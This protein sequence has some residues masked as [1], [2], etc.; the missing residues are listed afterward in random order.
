LYSLRHLLQATPAG[1][2]REFIAKLQ[3]LREQE[4]RDVRVRL[5]A[6]TLASILER[7]TADT[8][9]EYQWLSSSFVTSNLENSSQVRS[10]AQRMLDFADRRAETATLLVNTVRDT[11]KPQAVRT[12]SYSVFDDPRLFQFD[13]PDPI[14]D[15]VFAATVEMLRSPDAEM[16]RSGAGLLLNLCTAIRSS[17]RGMYLQSARASIETAIGAEVDDAVKVLLQ[18]YL[19]LISRLPA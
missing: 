1:T 17:N 13:Q 14:S 2:D 3:Q 18:A 5:A 7:G 4:S 8:D 16:R 6:S 12:S 19:E 9:E 15:M 10:F 11:T